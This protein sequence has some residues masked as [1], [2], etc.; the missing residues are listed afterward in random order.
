MI[1]AT[2]NQLIESPTRLQETHDAEERRS[3]HVTTS[4]TTSKLPMI[5]LLGVALEGVDTFEEAAAQTGD[6]LRALFAALMRQRQ[7]FA[8]DLIEE[9]EGA[10][11]STPSGGEN[12]MLV[13]PCRPASVHASRS[14]TQVLEKCAREEED[15][16]AAYQE[17]LAREE[18]SEPERHLLQWH[19]ACL[20][21]ARGEIR[22][23]QKNAFASPQWMKTH[24]VQPNAPSPAAD[25][26]QRPVGDR[27]I[28]SH[29]FS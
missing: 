6:G 13:E 29:R 2:S 9:I 14:L 1:M 19:L 10:E 21:A 28:I 7:E 17:V 18:L 4:L 11:N 26:S 25:K 15:A 12:Q 22:R 24:D 23:C 27:K 16:V 3:P 20:L 5:R 8:A